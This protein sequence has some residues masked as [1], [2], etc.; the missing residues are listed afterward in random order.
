[1][2]KERQVIRVHPVKNIKEL[3]NRIFYTSTKRLVEPALRLI[4]LLCENG[5]CT[6]FDTVEIS[7]KIYAR[8]EDVEYI[9]KKMRELGLIEQRGESIC[10]SDRFIHTLKTY[11]NVWQEV[12]K[13]A[14]R[15]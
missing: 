10:L 7:K 9:I 15:Q 3:M 13:A 2:P 11:I 4:E 8:I 14:K 5:G 6:N 12:L 1:M